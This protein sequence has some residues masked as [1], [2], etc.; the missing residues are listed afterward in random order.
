M[1]RSSVE[2]KWPSAVSDGVTRTQLQYSRPGRTSTVS[3]APEAMT[4]AKECGGRFTLACDSRWKSEACAEGEEQQGVR[5]SRLRR[6]RW[7]WGV[8]E[9]GAPASFTRPDSRKRPL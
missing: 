6:S 4:T 3:V 2:K 1:S 9:L 7:K 8:C 5:R